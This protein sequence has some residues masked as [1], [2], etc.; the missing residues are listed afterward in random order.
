MNV[1][2]KNAT[3][4]SS[5]TAT[6]KNLVFEFIEV[7]NDG[8]IAITLRHIVEA[9]RGSGITPYQVREAVDTLL[10]EGRILA[11]PHVDFKG[12][13]VFDVELLALEGA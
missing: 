7:H 1:T 6:I 2:H 11:L 10:L 12:E 9:A 3:R 8:G 13:L 4:K 5:L